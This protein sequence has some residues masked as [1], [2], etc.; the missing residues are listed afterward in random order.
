MAL[1]Y[2]IS[3]D[4]CDADRVAASV[5]ALN[6]PIGFHEQN[7]SDSDPVD[8]RADGTDKG[9]LE[10]CYDALEK[11]WQE[12]K[13]GGALP[14]VEQFLPSGIQE[15]L[16]ALRLL[17][18]MDLEYRLRHDGATR[19]ESYLARWPDLQEDQEFLLELLAWELELRSELGS[20]VDAEEYLKRFPSLP[21]H[22]IHRFFVSGDDKLSKESLPTLRA[23]EGSLPQPPDALPER[24]GRYSIDRM[25]G[26]GAFGI[27][28]RGYDERLKRHIAIKV[29]HRRGSANDDVTRF[30]SEAQLV[31]GLDHPAIVPVYDFG[32]SEDGRNFVVSK[33]I[34]GDNL[35]HRTTAKHAESE[36]WGFE[37]ASRIVATV[38]EALQYA[39]A[40]KICHRDVK[41][42]NI[43]LDESGNVYLSDFGLALTDEGFGS[44]DSLAGTPL[45]MSP[46][47]AAGESHL[48][49]GRSDIFSLGAVFYELLCGETHVGGKK[50]HEV[51]K[52]IRFSEARPLRQLDHRIPREL[53]R[54]CL[55]A[56][57]RQPTDRYW[58]AADLAHD[59]R[60]FLAPTAPAPISPPVQDAAKPHQIVPKGLRSFDEKDSSF[61]LDLLPGCR[62][63]EG[64]PER[65]QFWKERIEDTERDFSFR[66]GL[67]YGP[68]GSGKSSFVRAGLLPL[69]SQRVDTIY[70]E[71]TADQ[72][73]KHLLAQL[74]KRLSCEPD[75]T[76]LKSV[77]AVLRRGHPRGPGEKVLIVLDQFEQ[78]LHAN[79][80]EPTTALVQALRECD[81][82]HLQCLLLVRSDFWM[83]VTRL[84][85]QLDI[86]LREGENSA[87]VDLFDLTHARNVLHL[88]GTAYGKLPENRLTDDQEAFL[89]E[90]I[91][92]LATGDRVICVR[93]ALFA[94]MMRHKEWTTSSL[95]KIGGAE[96]VGIAFLDETFTRDTAPPLYRSHQMAARN[97]LKS[98]LPPRGSDIKGRALS[99]VDLLDASGYRSRPE[100]LQELMNILDVELRLITPTIHE[101]AA[102]ARSS[103]ELE[104][105]A[106]ERCYQLTHDYLVAPLREW[107]T[108]RQRETRRGRAQ[109]LLEERSA[110]W[111]ANPHS[112]QLPSWW[113]DTRIRLLT[114]R[115][116]WTEPDQTMMRASRRL[117]G[118]RLA[119]V[120]M[121]LL[122]LA[123]F[124][125]AAWTARQH[126]MARS[127]VNSLDR[128]ATREVP[129][130]IEELEPY[131]DQAVPLL[132]EQYDREGVGKTQKLHAALALTALGDPRVDDLCE[133]LLTA[134]PAE[135]ALIRDA[136]SARKLEATG[137]LWHEFGTDDMNAN[138]RRLRA[139]AALTH[140]DPTNQ[141]WAVCA[142]TLTRD[143]LHLLTLDPAATV[144]WQEELLPAAHHLLPTMSETL[145]DRFP[146]PSAT[147]VRSLLLYYLDN[148]SGLGRR[149]VSEHL[150]SLSI[151]EPVPAAS[152]TGQEMILN[153]WGAIPEAMAKRIEHAQGIVGERFAFCQSLALEQLTPLRAELQRYGYRL[154]SV[155]PY[156]AA[157][158][159]RLA[160]VWT[161]DGRNCEWLSGDKEQICAKHQELTDAKYSPI[162]VASWISPESEEVLYS[163]VWVEQVLSPPREMLVGLLEP[164]LANQLRQRF[165][166]SDFTFLSLARQR[167]SQEADV[168]SAIVSLQQDRTNLLLS[169]K[170]EYAAARHV[171]LMPVDIQLS[172]LPEARSFIRDYAEHLD[173]HPP[174]RYLRQCRQ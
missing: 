161:R 34:D 26:R 120:L 129:K 68:S 147:A 164:D 93:L 111:N 15:Q 40:R 46:E 78:W 28:Y 156:R 85:K 79:P 18:P 101:E 174:N 35:A 117:N 96:G 89:Q 153:R 133:Q 33:C 86:R 52:K 2:L 87:S 45:Y 146:E 4:P 171:G 143:L 71:S 77:L 152:E 54:I 32:T 173:A 95:A 140:Y 91:A 6:A 17:I 115:S 24:I 118:M 56:L 163:T 55:K 41:P 61:F 114:Q 136:L 16:A 97:V 134:S 142:P 102:T 43:L 51:L 112:R 98:L 74:V 137:K 127:L 126:G 53:E 138:Q 130:I 154:L 90:A 19:V 113:E 170:T 62:N 72:T 76:D 105:A 8:A 66:V 132:V 88:F 99:E 81:A 21:V 12:Y 29:P 107:L 22:S 7:M 59:L 1:A 100:Q 67:L 69:L 160:V 23:K 31:A 14:V 57:E 166:Q 104:V 159:T 63:R 65:I 50:L 165:G 157:G 92:G 70:V 124:G 49:D 167:T 110:A 64:L 20:A 121:L 119:S 116:R 123:G 48:V 44:V 141:R 25:L 9:I 39:H 149:V 172:T 80:V 162:D 36:R 169:P 3:I 131:A 108:R 145:I 42:A 168:M 58:N 135:Y 60:A 151:P 155:R 11:S 125:Y 128:A 83:P 10:D 84:Y 82:T 158:D 139:A 144:F 27:V 13:P 47:Q 94:E 30:L 73:E 75:Q 109:L 37:E 148:G 38:A 103:G 106:S 150:G 5:N 122:A